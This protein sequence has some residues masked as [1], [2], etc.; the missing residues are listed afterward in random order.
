MNTLK[1]MENIYMMLI[2]YEIPKEYELM[3]SDIIITALLIAIPIVLL[4]FNIRKRILL[5]KINSN[6]KIALKDKIIVS[7]DEVR[8]DINITRDELR[9]YISHKKE[10]KHFIF[11]YNYVIS[12]D[13]LIDYVISKVNSKNYPISFNELEFSQSLKKEDIKNILDII[14]K[15][16]EARG[17]YIYANSFLCSI[18]YLR[19]LYNEFVSNLTVAHIDPIKWLEIKGFDEVNQNFLFDKMYKIFLIPNKDLIIRG[20]YIYHIKYLKKL[21][22]KIVN[23][24]KKKIIYVPDWLQV[25]NIPEEDRNYIMSIFKNKFGLKIDKYGYYYTDD[26]YKETKRT[27]FDFIKSKGKVSRTE[28]YEFLD[29]KVIGFEMFEKKLSPQELIQSIDHKI[30]YDENYVLSYIAKKSDIFAKYSISKIAN[31]LNINIDVLKPLIT[32]FISENRLNAKISNDSIEFIFTEVPEKVSPQPVLI[33]LEGTQTV[34]IPGFKIQEVIG[35]GGFGT[36]FKAIDS[37]NN[38]IALKIITNFDESAKMEFIREA[39]IWKLFDHPHIV[40]LID[41]SLEPIPYISLELMEGTLRDFINKGRM[42]E[43]HAIKI[44]IDIL[45]AL[46]YVHNN[47]FLIHRDIKPENILYKQ[48]VFKLSDWTLAVLQNASMTSFKGTIAYSAPEQFDESYGSISTWTDIWQL[49]VVFY[50]LL[51]GK[52]PFGTAISEVIDKVLYKEPTQMVGISEDL[53]NIILQ[54][55]EKDPKKRIT[56]SEAISKLK[57]LL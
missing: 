48:N 32:K 1:I 27:I 22:N 34:S 51:V 15:S 18:D 25:I 6:I 31:E 9:R 5:N 45:S 33:G 21:Y 28:L 49:G 35:V 7:F 44:I 43:K 30:I 47:F 40:K 19:E 50:E 56:T 20:N 52:P 29:D 46:D 24:G 55:L 11:Y 57:E 14:K 8:K 13:G 3:I 38:E 23:Q 4:Y 12:K 17:V 26:I 41:Y 37:K 16:L 53:W 42:D 2:Q 36:V 54:M 10:G 39:E